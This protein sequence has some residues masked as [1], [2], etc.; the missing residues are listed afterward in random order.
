[1]AEHVFALLLAI[2]HGLEQAI[3]RTRKGDFSSRGLEGFDLFGKTLGVVG[4]GHIGQHAIRIARGFGME[5]LGYDV[6]P[7]E[8]AA[9]ELGFRYV[10]LEELL[11]ASDV[12]TRSPVRAL[13]EGKLAAGLDVLPEEPVIREEAEL[14]R[15]VYERRHNLEDLLADHVLL[16]LR[17]VIVTPHSAFRTREAIQRILDTTVRNIDAF[18][19]GEPG[20]IVGL[21][22]G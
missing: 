15:S 18:A 14:L 8:D 17:N 7:D 22:A 16:R 5:V 11:G 20:N 21:S 6:A 12:D 9:R 10:S 1:V 4:T 2:S 3:D 13:A 19:R